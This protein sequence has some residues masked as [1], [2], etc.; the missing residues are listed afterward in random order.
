MICNHQPSILTMKCIR[1]VSQE[2]RCIYAN[3]QAFICFLISCNI[4][5]I[6]AILLATLSG[7]PEP[8]SAMHLLWV[9]LVTDGPPATALA[10]AIGQSGGKL[11]RGMSPHPYTPSRRGCEGG[12]TGTAVLPPAPPLLQ[13][14]FALGGSTDPS[15]E[16]TD[17][18]QST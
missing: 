10:W 14:I 18:Q 12:G 11:L 3:M 9:N 15:C 2:G 13:H 6:C 7:V 5:E 4:G 8:L 16:R 17:K 1:F